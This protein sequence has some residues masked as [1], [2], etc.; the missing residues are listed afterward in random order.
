LYLV[1]VEIGSEVE[2]RFYIYPELSE[3]ERGKAALIPQNLQQ[4]YGLLCMSKW[5]L[6]SD[7]VLLFC[8]PIT[9]ATVVH[10]GVCEERYRGEVELL[11]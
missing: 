10:G 6:R 5:D 3:Q 1:V 11:C 8:G 4:C 2:L 9:P 7:V